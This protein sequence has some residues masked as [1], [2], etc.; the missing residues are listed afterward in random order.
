MPGNTRT[1]RMQYNGKAKKSL[2]H[3]RWKRKFH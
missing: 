3:L 1:Q 2:I